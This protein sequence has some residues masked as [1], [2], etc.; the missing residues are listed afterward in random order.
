MRHVKRM[1]ELIMGVELLIG[2][3]LIIAMV[4]IMVLEVIMRYL[5]NN[6]IIWVQEF[7]IMIFIW[8]VMLGGSAA[9]MT[10]THVTITTFSQRLP[11]KWKVVLQVFVSLIVLAVL[12]Y[13]LQT[14]PA[15]ISI[16]NKTKTSSMPLNIGKGHF[17][18][19]PLFVAVIL[20]SITE[21]YYLFYEV[22]LLLGKDI[23]EDYALKGYR[24]YKTATA[25]GKV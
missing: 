2:G 1:L 16:Q 21:L 24:F 19:T 8:M 23:P 18:S 11:G 20:M 15:S 17:Y 7:V 6:S 3:L 5:F 25:G 12:F 4:A 10:K 13:L 14:L 22:C 9:S